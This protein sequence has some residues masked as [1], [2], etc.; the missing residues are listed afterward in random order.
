[1][2]PDDLGIDFGAMNDLL[3]AKSAL[4]EATAHAKRMAEQARKAENA[5]FEAIG[6]FHEALSKYRGGAR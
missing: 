4:D 5:R 3:W 6:R 1:M 2:N